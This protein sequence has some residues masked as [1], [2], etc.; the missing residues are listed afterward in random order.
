MRIGSGGRFMEEKDQIWWEAGPNY[1][2]ENI[3]EVLLLKE[4]FMWK[5]LRAVG[6]LIRE[7]TRVRMDGRPHEKSNH[8]GAPYGNELS[9]ALKNEELC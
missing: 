3:D 5:K 8:Q 1:H 4:S 6:N 9:V 2:L 7:S